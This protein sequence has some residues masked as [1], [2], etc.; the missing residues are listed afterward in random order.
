MEGVTGKNGDGEDGDKVEGVTGKNANKEV[1]YSSR[2][3]AEA[4]D[5]FL[6]YTLALLCMY[7]TFIMMLR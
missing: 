7:A 6:F 4:S 1:Y 5:S 3:G 2:R